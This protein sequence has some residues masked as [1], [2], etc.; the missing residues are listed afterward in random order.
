MFFKPISEHNKVLIGLNRDEN[1]FKMFYISNFKV[2]VHFANSLLKD[3]HLA[4]DVASE[5]MWKMWNL[6]SD[7]MNIASIEK[8][9]IRAVKNRCLNILRVKKMV[10]EDENELIKHD[11][12]LDVVCPEHILINIEA[13]RKIE[14]AIEQLPSKTKQVFKHVKEDKASYKQT[15]EIMDISI[16]TVDRHIQIALQKLYQSLKKNK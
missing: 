16:K 13:V 1:A 10:Y 3:K 9:L 6:G 5:T 12:R 2:L 14:L 4:E 15:A 7:L 8:Y 11:N